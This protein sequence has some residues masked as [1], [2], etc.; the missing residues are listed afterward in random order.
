[1]EQLRTESVSLRV[2]LNSSEEQK[3][4][5]AVNNSDLTNSIDNLRVER[6][7]LTERVRILEADVGLLN[8][9]VEE[10]SHV[11]SSSSPEIEQ[12]KEKF[13]EMARE[14]SAVREVH[15]NNEHLKSRLDE[16]NIELNSLRDANH[17][18]K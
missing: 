2:S 16:L 9:Q 14:S 1:M 18:L 3:Q 8:T 12:L 7:H 6:D 11:M 17:Q 4:Q 15:A 10:L 13:V 5:L